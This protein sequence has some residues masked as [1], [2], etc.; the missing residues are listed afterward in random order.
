[1]EIILYARI[2]CDIIDLMNNDKGFFRNLIERIERYLPMTFGSLIMFVIILYLFVVVGR[3]VIINY[4]SNKSI[5]AEAVKVEGLRGEIEYLNNQI[6]YLQTN[7]FKEKEAR[8]KLAYKA[9]GESVIALPIDQ[10]E[11]KVEGS[12]PIADNAV[13]VSNPRLWI[14]YFFGN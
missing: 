13:K 9:P 11:D 4:K 6:A 1:L 12:T 3:M 2:S 14:K 8:A 5:D 10:P 7:S